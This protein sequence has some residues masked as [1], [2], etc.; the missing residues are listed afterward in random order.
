MGM[1]WS[2]IQL[3]VEGKSGKIMWLHL[4]FKKRKPRGEARKIHTG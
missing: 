3:R 1:G 4:N 2:R